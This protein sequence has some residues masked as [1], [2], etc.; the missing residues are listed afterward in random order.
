MKGVCSNC[1]GRVVGDVAKCPWCGA[2]TAPASTAD[3]QS[4]VRHSVHDAARKWASGV[5]GAPR[6]LDALITKIGVRDEVIERVATQIVRRDIHQQWAFCGTTRPT[7]P[8][9][10]GTDFDPF[11]L[12]EQDLRIATEHVITCAV[13]NGNGQTACQGCNGTG[14]CRC[15]ACGGSGK[16]VKYHKNGTTRLIKCRTC[17]TKGTVGC[18]ACGADG[19]IRCTGCSG[20]GVQLVWLA[21]AVTYRWDLR[22]EP[23]SPVASAHPQLKELRVLDEDDLAPFKVVAARQEQGPVE[24]HGYRDS[25]AG[26]AGKAARSIDN[27][28]ERICVQ[29][30]VKLSVVRRDVEYEMCGSK[31]T[32]VLSGLD[33]AGAA[34]PEAVA[35]IQRRLRMWGGTIVAT[36]VGAGLLAYHFT[37]HAAY[38]ETTN[39]LVSALAIAA[40]ALSIPFLGGLLRSWKGGSR[41]AGIAKAELCAG[42]AT[43]AAVLGIVAVGLALRPRTS[44]VDAAVTAGNLIRARHVLEALKE[45]K[46]TSPEVADAEDAVLF[47]EAKLMAGDA[48]LTALDAVAQRHGARSSKAADLARGDRLSRI[49]ALVDGNLA[50]QALTDIDKMFATTASTDADVAEQKAKAHEQ[51]AANCDQDGCRLMRAA[52]ALAAAPNPQRQAQ[53]ATL[54]TQALAFLRTKGAPDETPLAKVKRVDLLSAGAAAVLGIPGVDTGL[55]TSAREAATRAVTE[56][57]RVALIGADQPVLEQVLGAPLAMKGVIGSVLLDGMR[58]FVVLDA[59]KRCR[60]LY[61]VGEKAGARQ[62]AGTKWT[63]DLVMAQAVGHDAAVKSATSATGVATSRWFEAPVSVVA[64]WKDGKLVELRIGDA[65]P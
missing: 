37:G 22:L 33:L 5:Q 3:A 30:Y 43:L 11:G 25:S 7:R 44:E 53:V 45:T 32:L 58:V 8:K 18:P 34:R 35:P 50:A 64:R 36:A 31:G 38:F 59:A 2:S 55:L 21:Y 24:V 40:A 26:L 12:S 9:V 49:R 39:M 27:R 6:N 47:A 19:R 61:L 13:C 14:R 17:G 15:G 62:L 29:Q 1:A 48:R 65:A 54:K 41:V 56:R 60:G 20:S 23:D 10:A 51:L 52:A 4:D 46:P 28:H 42:A 63:P 57:S 16:E